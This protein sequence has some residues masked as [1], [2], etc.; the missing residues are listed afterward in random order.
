MEAVQFK[1]FP[2]WLSLCGIG[3]LVLSKTQLFFFRQSSAHLDQGL[4]GGDG[5]FVDPTAVF[6]FGLPVV[7]FSLFFLN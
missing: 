1:F 4:Y 3:L 5:L 6:S 7:S 2:Y